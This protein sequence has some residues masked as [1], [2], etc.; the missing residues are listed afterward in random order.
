MVSKAVLQVILVIIKSEVIMKGI[1]IL[2]IGMVIV[3]YNPEIGD[4]LVGMIEDAIS[5]INSI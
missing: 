3:A 1:A 2:V 5:S 4:V